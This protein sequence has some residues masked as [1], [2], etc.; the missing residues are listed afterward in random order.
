MIFQLLENRAHN[1]V[2]IPTINRQT[3]NSIQIQSS[4]AV[5]PKWKKK[6]KR[7][8]TEKHSHHQIRQTDQSRRVSTN[9]SIITAT[10][11]RNQIEN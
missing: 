10:Q 1:S 6:E 4:N 11:F 7:N 5:I 3:A 9:K 8:Q 2:S